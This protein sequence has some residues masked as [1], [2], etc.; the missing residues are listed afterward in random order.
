[1]RKVL[2]V[3]LAACLSLAGFILLEVPLGAQVA[4]AADPYVRIDLDEVTPDSL[5]AKATVTVRGTITNT[6]GKPLKWL[7]VALWRNRYPI[8]TPGDLQY[9]LSSP[10]EVPVGAR[11][12][13]PDG[14]FV[15]LNSDAKPEF[16]AGEKARFTLHATVEQLGLAD[17]A[18]GA[19]H[20]L[21]VHVMGYPPDGDNQLLARSRFLMPWTPDQARKDAARVSP[22]VLLS[23][24]PSLAMDGTFTDDH[25]ADELTGRLATLMQVAEKPGA[26][27]LVDPAL[28]DEVHRMSRGYRIGGAT[29]Q[30]VVATDPRA[31]AAADWL[32]RLDALRTSGRLYRT[33]FG[34]PNLTL[35]AAQKRGDIV[36]RTKVALPSTHSLS[37]LPVAVW[38]ADQGTL[39]RSVRTFLAP[40]APS[41]WVEPGS[42]SAVYRA[43][44]STLLT[45]QPNATS[46]GPGP[47][48]SDSVPQRR[49][50]LLSQMLIEGEPIILPVTNAAEA[51]TVLQLPAWATSVPHTDLPR[52]TGPFPEPRPVVPAPRS[53]LLRDIDATW[54]RIQNWHDLIGTPPT[55]ASNQVVSRAL[56]PAMGL[57]SA[58]SWLAQATSSVPRASGHGIS[59]SIASSFVM[60]DR[61]TRLPVTITNTTDHPVRVKVVMTSDNPGRITIPET[62][63]VTVPAGQSATVTF[64]PKATTNGVVGFSAQLVTEANRPVGPSKRFSVNATNFGQVGW[65]IIIASGAVLLGGTAIRIRQVQHE[66]AAAGAS[67]RSA[68]AEAPRTDN[69]SRPH[70]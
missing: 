4:H 45:Y 1:M 8:A 67:R 21:G 47:A 56:N 31:V 17:G 39:P 3:L 62:A 49:G 16:K 65:I 40:L 51:A 53:S 55:N 59:L 38:P 63:P 26:T 48:P 41:L 37:S 44:G 23:S 54:K 27:I 10:E 19:V 30:E 13:N 28:Y 60:G 43:E 70:P 20:L 46:G 61:S 52:A 66:R 7:S 14:G 6:T 25:L 68:G 29:P 12:T 11:L 9:L 57:P 34:N 35:A 58:R 69:T 2:S 24:A 22:L 15:N 42:R 32:N 18:P 5:D 36:H 33:P 64:A 50:R